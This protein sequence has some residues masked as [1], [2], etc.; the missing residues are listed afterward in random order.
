MY[1][2]SFQSHS[3]RNR[4]CSSELLGTGLAAFRSVPTYMICL[5]RFSAVAVGVGLGCG[6]SPMPS[7]PTAQGTISVVFPARLAAG[8]DYATEVLGDPWDMC[9][10]EDVTLR[11]DEIVGW[12]TFNF[13]SAPCRLGGT[14][15]AV[16]GTNDS[17]VMMLSPGMYDLALNPGRNGR[18]F[19]IDT[20]KYQV[21]S[22]KLIRVPPE[23]PQVW[24]YH[25]P[26]NHPAGM[27]LAAGSCRGCLLE[28]S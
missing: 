27:V 1:Q 24:W 16:N 19:P 6:L 5:K 12:A 3:G 8:P 7:T 23:D 10:R 17:S 15:M 22:A 4:G 13:L 14:T 26:L 28:R 2:S 9:N 21:L 25:N 11:P 18:N 20:S